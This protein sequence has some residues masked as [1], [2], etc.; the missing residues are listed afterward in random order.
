MS[1][2]AQSQ[3]AQTKSQFNEVHK[4]KHGNLTVGGR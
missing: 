4:I 3:R 2:K 1:M